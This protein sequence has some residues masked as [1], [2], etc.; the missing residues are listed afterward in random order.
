LVPRLARCLLFPYTT[1][2]R[3]ECALWR[4]EEEKDALLFCDC[5]GRC[6]NKKT[7]TDVDVAGKRVFC[8]VDFNVPLQ[9]GTITDDTRIRAALRSEEHTSEL[10]S[11]ETLVC[12]L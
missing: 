5:G 11:R 4:V 8:R 2:F 9:E 12:R 6:M 7:I 10:H 1:L 3:S